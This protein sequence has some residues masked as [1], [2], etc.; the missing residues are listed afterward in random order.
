M[1]DC[2]AYCRVERLFTHRGS[3]TALFWCEWG[4][5]DVIL[6]GGG[7]ALRSSKY[8]WK[9]AKVSEYPTMVV[10]S[11]FSWYLE[12][13]GTY[14]CL[15]GSLSQIMGIPSKND[16]MTE[17]KNGYI[18]ILLNIFGNALWSFNCL[19]YIIYTYAENMGANLLWGIMSYPLVMQRSY[20]KS[21][22]KIGRWNRSLNHH[23]PAIP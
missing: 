14:L 19:P 22:F 4:C 13:L 16:D 23:G 15:I 17:W 21:S 10:T 18:T 3:P 8:Q 7:Y 20:G 2:V 9:W 11:F 12:G 1:Q 5:L 6:F